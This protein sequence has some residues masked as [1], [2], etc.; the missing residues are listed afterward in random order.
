MTATQGIALFTETL[1]GKHYSA[2]STNAY[3][4]DRAQFVN[5]LTNFLFQLHFSAP[6]IAQTP[7]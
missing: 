6:G 3:R 7:S 2:Q 1:Q 5:Q 4:S